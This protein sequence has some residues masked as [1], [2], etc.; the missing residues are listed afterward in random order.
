MLLKQHLNLAISFIALDYRLSNVSSV[1]TFTVYILACH[2]QNIQNSL[3]RLLNWIHWNFFWYLL[4]VFKIVNCRL[5]P[6]SLFR[7]LII[8]GFM[9]SP[10]VPNASFL[11]P[12][13]T[14]ENLKIF[15]F[16]QVVEKGSIVKNFLKKYITLFTKNLHYRMGA[17][18]PYFI[19][20][21]FWIF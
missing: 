5:F 7:L 19:L 2:F 12:L 3:L 1:S 9:I 20:S 4:G 18:Y 6:I 11:Y 21:S 10:F 16:F 8:M 13:K 14:S 17:R 15:W